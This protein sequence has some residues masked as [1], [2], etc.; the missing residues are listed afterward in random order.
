MPIDLQTTGVASVP[1][2]SLGG[3]ISL[4]D[5]GTVD[6]QSTDLIREYA[7]WLIGLLVILI[8]GLSVGYLFH[9]G[10]LLFTKFNAT[11]PKD[12]DDFVTNSL[13]PYLKE[14]ATT[15]GTIFGSTL[16]FV[17]G[18][19]FKAASAAAPKNP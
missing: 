17:F 12:L 4:V 3:G 16:G 6:K 18:Y 2:S 15:I 9:L 11:Q 14:C 8:F 13:D 19:Y 7:A 5:T 10:S 1:P